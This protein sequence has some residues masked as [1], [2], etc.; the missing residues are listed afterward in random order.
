[1]TLRTDYVAVDHTNIS[2]CVWLC[3][4]MC[5][6]IQIISFNESATAKPKV[7][8]V[9]KYSCETETPLNSID[10][11]NTFLYVFRYFWALIITIV[12]SLVLVKKYYD[13]Y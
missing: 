9:N 5:R 13:S 8:L 4:C 6:A 7:T 2:T 3:L 11:A 10:N 12:F 1:M